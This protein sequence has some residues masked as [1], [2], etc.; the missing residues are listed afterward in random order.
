MATASGTSIYSR[1]LIL[2]SSEL[3]ELNPLPP[4]RPSREMH[5]LTD[6]DGLPADMR[7]NLAYGRL[8]TVLP[9]LRQDGYDRHRSLRAQPSIVMENDRLRATVLP[10]LGGRL[11]SLWHKATQRELLF[12]NP[13]L[14]FAN[15]ALRDAWFAGGVEWNLGSTGHTTLTCEPMHAAVVDGPEGDPILRLWEWERTRGLV[16]QVDLWLPADSELLFVGVRL[17]NPQQVD[18][19]VYWWSNIAVAQ[20][21]GLRVVAPADEAWHF[22]YEQRLQLVR[23]NDSAISY[24]MRHQSAADYFFEIPDGQRRWIAGLDQAGSGL[25]QASTSIL[26]GRKLF[27]WGEGSGGRRWQ[28]WLAPGVPGHGYAEIQ[29]G[30]ARTQMEHLRMPA[31][32]S[33]DWLEA[34]GRI[35]VDPE[36]AHH[37][38]WSQAR[39]GVEDVLDGLLP[40]SVLTA[41]HHQWQT[42]AELGPTGQRLS[43][44]SGWGALE[45]ARLAGEGAVTLAGTPFPAADIADPQ[46]PWLELARTGALPVHPPALPPTGT[47]WSDPW[48]A[49]LEAAPDSWLVSYHRGVARWCRGDRDGAVHAWTHSL[50]LT[51][52][53]WAQRNLA[54]AALESSATGEALSLLQQAILLDPASVPLLLE[55][56]ETALA[57]GAAEVAAELLRTVPEDQRQDGRFRLAEARTALLR[58]DAG[59]AAEIFDAG[60]DYPNLREGGR[61][62]TETWE[63]I[64]RSIG[65]R[66]PLPGR[67]DFRMFDG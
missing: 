9:Y 56:I 16:Y 35:D 20:T 63:A 67:Y 14:Q 8:D 29:A 23:L 42:V 55:T 57:A 44:G 28:D 26:R 15:L 2:P 10:G 5:T 61:I 60:F 65:T 46:Q 11:Y 22:G 25:V 40:D 47:L 24:P 39:H 27:V 18:I 7:E 53:A 4:L 58:G 62:L 33:W 30:L 50:E 21:P 34:Y 54:V 38:D 51:P 1:P 6:L 31:G 3:G 36:A 48:W 37:P 59:A 17:Q 52:N 41:R 13:V 66:R 64:Q 12:C 19:P 49:L 45:L 43:T 32:A